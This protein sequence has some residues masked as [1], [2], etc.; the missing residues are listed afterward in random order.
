M[1]REFGFAIERLRKA[2]QEQSDPNP[3]DHLLSVQEQIDAIGRGDYA[4]AIAGALDDV[5][6][7]IFAPLEFPWIRR[8][9]GKEAFQDALQVNFDSVSDQTPEIVSVMSQGDTVVVIGRERGVIRKTGRS[10]DVQFAHRFTFLDG[11]LAAV[12]V[13]VAYTGE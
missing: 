6:L 5:E 2:R 3:P 9:R 12:Q 4:A 1:P 10:Y 11:Y 13:I 7:A 8:A